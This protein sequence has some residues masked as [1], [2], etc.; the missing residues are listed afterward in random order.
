MGGHAPKSIVPQAISLQ[1]W[2]RMLRKVGRPPALS[3][4]FIRFY[5]FLGGYTPKKH[6]IFSR[7]TGWSCSEFCTMGWKIATLRAHTLSEVQLHR[8]LIIEIALARMV[9]ESHLFLAFASQLLVTLYSKL[10]SQRTNIYPILIGILS[11]IT[12]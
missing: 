10:H 1:K 12:G 6:W 7:E 9:D 8:F 3:A 4:F 11:Q 5:R 2:V